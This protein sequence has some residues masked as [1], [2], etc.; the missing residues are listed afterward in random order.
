MSP[1]CGTRWGSGAGS[2]SSAPNSA[3]VTLARRVLARASS[4][5]MRPWLS[6][7]TRRRMRSTIALSCVAT[8]TVV[9]VR[10]IR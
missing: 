5:T 1:A 8:T 3:V 9:P 2:R 4:R 6:S 10:L 7:M